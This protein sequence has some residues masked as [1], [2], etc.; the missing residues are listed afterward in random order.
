MGACTVRCTRRSIRKVHCR[1]TSSLGNRAHRTCDLFSGVAVAARVFACLRPRMVARATRLCSRCDPFR[2]CG[3]LPIWGFIVGL[4]GNLGLCKCSASC[5]RTAHCNLEIHFALA[6][7][8]RCHGGISH[9]FQVLE[10]GG[11]FCVSSDDPETRRRQAPE[12]ERDSCDATSCFLRDRHAY[13]GTRFFLETPLICTTT[14]GRTSAQACPRNSRSGFC[15][16]PGRVPAPL[17][18]HW[19][20]R[21]LSVRSGA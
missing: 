21:F 10:P 4:L 13:R 11:G 1:K 7:V 2:L 6:S 5:S 15:K 16:L 14:W 20:F 19:S 3:F 18:I 12:A 17:V 9:F 8:F